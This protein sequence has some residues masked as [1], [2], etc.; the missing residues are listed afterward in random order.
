MLGEG[1]AIS[2]WRPSFWRSSISGGG[3]SLSTPG[4]DCGSGG[5]SPVELAYVGHHGAWLAW[6]VAWIGGASWGL[7]WASL[8][9]VLCLA[10]NAHG[11]RFFKN[12][13]GSPRVASG[14]RLLRFR[15]PFV[16]T[17]RSYGDGGPEGHGH[18][19]LSG[20]AAGELAT[21]NFPENSTSRHF[22]E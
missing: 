4:R 14:N 9:T 15:A 7:L 18:P 21:V 11:R 13:R 3:I 20:A 8:V 12:S 5:L 19:P 17:W 2:V 16:A 10:N 22:G 6:R 1:S